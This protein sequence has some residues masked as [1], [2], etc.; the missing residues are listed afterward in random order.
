MKRS[1]LAVTALLAL[2]APVRA[3]SDHA[4]LALPTEGMQFLAYYVAEDLGFFAQ[5]QLE[6]KKQVIEGET[7]GR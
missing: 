5:E 4:L 6:M 3:E 2:A 7:D 1:I